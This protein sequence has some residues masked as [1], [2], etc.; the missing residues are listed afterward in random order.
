D[1][2]VDDVDTDPSVP[3][4]GDRDLDLGAHAV[5]AGCKLT[6]PRQRE[7]AGERTHARNHLLAVGGGDQRLDPLERALVSLDADAGRGVRQSFLAHTFAS[8]GEG[9]GSNCILSM[10][11]CVRTGSGY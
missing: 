9:E 10:S 1:A 3:G 4:R 5:C 2:V 11:S 7:E 8:W 6:A